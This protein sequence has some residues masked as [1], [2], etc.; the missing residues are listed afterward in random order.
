[1]IYH[2]GEFSSGHGSLAFAA[3]LLV[4]F[5]ASARTRIVAAYLWVFADV[6]NA[7]LDLTVD[8]FPLSVQ[9]LEIGMLMVFDSFAVSRIAGDEFDKALVVGFTAAVGTENAT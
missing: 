2:G 7:R 4:F 6:R 8:E 1:M 5:A 9:P 3:A